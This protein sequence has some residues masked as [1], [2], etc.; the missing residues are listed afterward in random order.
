[1]DKK[2][3]LEHALEPVKASFEKEGRTF[4]RWMLM[5]YDPRQPRGTYILV[6][7][8]EWI[9]DLEHRFEGPHIIVD[10]I[11]H[12]SNAIIPEIAYVLTEYHPDR[13]YGAL[14]WEE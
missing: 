12:L 8:G 11:W 2:T 13:V 14:A 6:A 10:R 9:K 1:M 5:P 4:T 7:E 3:R